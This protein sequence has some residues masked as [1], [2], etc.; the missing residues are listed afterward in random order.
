MLRHFL[1]LAV[2]FAG[3][4]A[5]AADRLI[6]RDLSVITNRTV[7]SCDEDGARLNEALEDGRTTLRWDEILRGKVSAEQQETFDALL[8]EFGLPLFRLR[9][10]ITFGDYRALYEPAKALAPKFLERKSE[11]AYLVAQS[12]MWG[13]LANG[14]PEAAVAPYLRAYELI[15]LN[16]ADPKRLPGDRRLQFDAQSGLCT[17]LKPLWFDKEAA[18]QALPEVRE[19][20][21]AM[22]M[23]RPEATR[24]YYG[25]LAV[26]A[27]DEGTAAKMLD[28]WTPDS[29]AVAE[30]QR[31]A[32][33]QREIKQGK[34]GSNV[35]A[36]A[37]EVTK[38][39]PENRPLAEY[40][41]AVAGIQETGATASQDAALD[42]LAIPAKYGAS[43][44]LVAAAALHR[45]MLLLEASG[46]T[47]GG[48]AV[49]RELLARYPT[50]WQARAVRARPVAP[51]TNG[52]VK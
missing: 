7:T 21:T 18:A 32:L 5:F 36:L 23:P 34:P 33:V 46:D 52:G 51:A 1:L 45:T 39:S 4:P 10:R 31:I 16:I 3:A 42:L 28:G 9:Q 13:A 14:E 41:L 20:I 6:L 17:D 29:L 37:K 12:L 43:Q 47:A 30:L 48:A 2:F 19:A 15:R 24:L 35:V 8:K 44:P 22:S 50:T 11:T 25:A 40:W 27:D 38:L 49:A 26:V